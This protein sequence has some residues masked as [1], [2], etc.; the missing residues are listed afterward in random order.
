[1]DSKKLFLPLLLLSAAM[2]WAGGIKAPPSAESVSGLKAWIEENVSAADVSAEIEGAVSA[3]NASTGTS[4]HGLGTM[5]IATATDYVATSTFTDHTG[6]KANPHEVTYTQVGA[7]ASSAKAVDADK[8][9]GLDSADYTTTSTFTGHT[10]ATGTSVH[11]LGTMS[12]ATATDYVAVSGANAMTADLKFAV[13]KGICSA[14]TT[15]FAALFGGTS[16]FN[17][18]SGAG[19][20]AY[21]NTAGSG[22]AGALKFYMGNTST[23]FVDFLIPSGTSA[24]KIASDASCAFAGAV[25]FTATP[26]INGVDVFGDIS[27]AL[28]EI[29]GAP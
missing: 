27:T 2:A 9:D 22:N 28:D 24:L 26:T 10:G 15:G 20:V 6:D 18:N 17:T 21:G 1:M 13:N 4:V 29:I 12:T 8:L 25:N 23:A 3:H 11:G 7:L 5:S 16:T 19:L 14:V